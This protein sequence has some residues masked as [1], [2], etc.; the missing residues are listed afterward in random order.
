MRVKAIKVLSDL[1]FKTD[2]LWRYHGRSGS[3]VKI[4]GLLPSDSENRKQD[5]AHLRAF[6]TNKEVV[7]NKVL[8]ATN[9][10]IIAYCLL[11][12]K[13]LQDY[14]ESRKI[15]EL[16]PSRFTDPEEKRPIKKVVSGYISSWKNPLR[17]NATDDKSPYFDNIKYPVKPFEPHYD[18][19]RKL[20]ESLFSQTYANGSE[21][22][23]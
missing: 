8:F 23:Q 9:E 21:I 20:A 13:P 4:A 3:L 17:Y 16:E 12:G 10:A 2:K 22:D 19:N 7:I 14:F 6:L 15:P 11:D 1:V 5:I 18:N